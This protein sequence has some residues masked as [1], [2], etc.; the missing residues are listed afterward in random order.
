MSVIEDF[1]KNSVVPSFNRMI[2]EASASL[3]N[4]FKDA[5][6]VNKPSQ[7]VQTLSRGRFSPEQNEFQQTATATEAAKALGRGVGVVAGKLGQAA[8]FPGISLNTAI[9]AVGKVYEGVQRV[10]STALLQAFP[11]YSGQLG[12]SWKDAADIPVSQP[13]ATLVTQPARNILGTAEA[14]LNPEQ[15][16]KLEQSLEKYAPFLSPRFDLTDNEQRVQAYENNWTGAVFTGGFSLFQMWAEGAGVGALAKYSRLKTGIEQNA[17]DSIN[18][19]KLQSTEGKEW[20]QSLSKTPNAEVSTPPNG[21]SVLFNDI[22]QQSSPVKLLE[23]PLIK[24]L[25]PE[26]QAKTASVYADAKNWDEVEAIF[27]ATTGDRAAFDRLWDIKASAA[28]T[29]NDFDIFNFK[30]FTYPISPLSVFDPERAAKINAVVDDIAKTDP[31]LAK[32]TQDWAIDLGSQGVGTG[33]W[34]PSRFASIEQAR[35]ALG[36]IRNQRL[37]NQADQA[38]TNKGT[39]KGT[40]VQKNIF[41]RPI[42]VLNN[43]FGERPRGHIDYSDPRSIVDARNEFI[44]EINEVNWLRAPEYSTF[45][46]DLVQKY[47]R[48]ANPTERQRVADQIDQEIVAMVGSRYGLTPEQSMEVYDFLKTKRNQGQAHV[49]VNGNLPLEN[50]SIIL[51]DPITRSQMATDHIIL[52]YGIL[53]RALAKD[54]G[55]TAQRESLKSKTFR[56]GSEGFDWLNSI[57]SFAV[58]VKPGYIPKNSILEPQLRVL[59][60]GDTL[61]QIEQAIPAIKNTAINVLNKTVELPGDIV[62]NSILRQSPKTIKNRIKEFDLSLKNNQ[63]IIAEQETSIRNIDINLRRLEIARKRS[64]A[65]GVE[66]LKIVDEIADLKNEKEL[67]IAKLEDSKNL[68]EDLTAR[69]EEQRQKLVKI[70]SY[71]ATLKDKKS[72]LDEDAT[73]E[74]DGKTFTVPG[75][76]STKAKGGLALRAE[77]D[78]ANAVYQQAIQNSWSRKYTI[79]RKQTEVVK[80]KPGDDD[81]WSEFAHEVNVRAKND[82]IVKM[83]AAGVSREDA[84]AWLSGTKTIPVTTV[85]NGKVSTEFIGKKSGNNYINQVIQRLS[86]TEY[87]FGNWYANYVNDIYNK[88][89]AYIPDVDLR[90]DAIVRNLTPDELEAR[91]MFRDDLPAVDGK[92]VIYPAR[93]IDTITAVLNNITKGGYRFIQKP[94]FIISKNPFLLRRWS[95]SIDRQIRQATSLGVEVTN[96]L[97]NDRFRFVA[98]SEVIRA[99]EDTFYTVRRQNNLNYYLR[100]LMGFP[101]ALINSYKFWA[102]AI[103]KNPYNAVIQYKVQNLPYEAGLVVD[104]DGNPVKRDT[105]KKEGEQRFLIL[106]KPAWSDPQNLEPYT[107]KIDINQWNSL[108]LGMPGASWLLQQSVS[109]LVSNYPEWEKSIQRVFGKTVYNNVLYG[110]RPISGRNW[111]EKFLNS[112]VPSWL[113]TTG[114]L[115]KQT[116]KSL[117]KNDLDFPFVSYLF[118]YIT[119]PDIKDEQAFIDRYNLL[120]NTAMVNWVAKGSPSDSEPNEKVIRREAYD[121]MVEDAFIKIFAP[122]GI[123][124]QPVTQ[125]IKE[126]ARSLT[127]LYEQGILERKPGR[128]SYQSAQEDMALLYSQDISRLMG[129]SYNKSA[130]VESSFESFGVYKENKAFLNRVADKFGDEYIGMIVNPDVPGEYSPAVAS[131]MRNVQ[132]GTG[133]EGKTLAGS[134]KSIAENQADFER[135]M[136]WQERLKLK[137]KYDALLAQSGAKSYAKRPDLKAQLDKD[138]LAIANKYPAWKD[139]FLNPEINNADAALNVLTLTIFNEDV[140]KYKKGSRKWDAVVGYLFDREEYV[141]RI[142]EAG[143][144]RNRIKQ[145]KEEWSEVQQEWINSDTFFADMH[146]RWLDNDNMTKGFAWYLAGEK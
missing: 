53:D 6:I 114:T 70:T 107:K 26:V 93:K 20:F 101:T 16:L 38:G 95:E 113:D 60:I 27:F 88:Y 109:N 132:I 122:F 59:A 33:A 103:L 128:N 137:A 10:A 99:V 73:F 129:S 36:N 82:E 44:S 115:A 52:P 108:S 146:A 72:I 54:F 116:V 45:K 75:A 39:I 37:F 120:Y 92:K 81:Y 84:I 119:D 130:Y 78:P 11:G 91:Y 67:A 104:Q 3:T 12:K 63:K 145:L 142:Q 125:F 124:K 58:L 80:I 102:K 106:G 4:V 19:L 24:M 76:L 100:F 136:G 74:I 83:W 55:T 123:I 7:D 42:H 138:S 46:E 143:G 51:P 68:V 22:I 17:F 90:Q 85:K 105:P 66:D 94:E 69:M 34:A 48:A 62:A 86:G 18:D 35:L 79:L 71:R 5:G 140:M 32:L 139:D 41:T 135:R 29:L 15:T 8:I 43:L 112:F 2:N 21:I 118:G 50:E 56:A 64:V 144:N 96:D 30:N 133:G 87:E 25:P 40:T 65:E 13:L 9:G 98:N 57:F 89:D 134:K 28:D 126:Q 127:D 23:N 111:F 47:L 141:R 14:I 110:G 61:N 117:A 97:I 121:S 77:L 49:A 131:W 31:E 1:L